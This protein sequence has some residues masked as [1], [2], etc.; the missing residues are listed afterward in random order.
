MGIDKVLKIGSL[1][2]VDHKIKG[3]FEIK[4]LNQDGP[5]IC[6]VITSGFSLSVKSTIQSGPGDMVTLR[7]SHTTVVECE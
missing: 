3:Q 6:G 7:K 2:K 4:L 1:Y 5:F